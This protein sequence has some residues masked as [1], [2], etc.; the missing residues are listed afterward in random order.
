LPGPVVD[1]TLDGALIA[2]RNRAAEENDVHL[3]SARH[4]SG[5]HIQGRDCSIGHV[6]DFVIDDESWQISLLD[7]RYAQLVVR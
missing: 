1:P 3:R 6:E 2:E 5:Y 7:H 4:V